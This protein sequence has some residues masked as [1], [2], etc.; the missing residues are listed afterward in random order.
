MIAHYLSEADA[1]AYHAGFSIASR[2]I[3]VL[4]V[5]FGAAGAP[6]MIHALEGGGEGALREEARR[7]IVLMALVLFPATAGIIAV[8]A[9]LSSLL[10]G[11]GL[12]SRALSITPLV[13]VGALLAGMNNSYF[14]LSFT[15]AKKTRLLVI[16]MAIPALANI[17]LNW[18]LIPRLGLVGAASAY[19]ASFVLGVLVAWALGFKARRMPTPLLELGKIA[20]AAAVMAAALR[21]IPPMGMAVDLMAKP[22]LGL[23]IY[24]ALAYGLDLGGARGLIDKALGRMAPAPRAAR[25]LL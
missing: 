24:G 10:I 8:A 21:L 18:L 15:L 6:A 5:W 12:R 22:A 17:A 9:P 14:L 19:L 3:E 1:G 2:V 7:Q 4:F 11:E 23:L 16:A 25:N 20:A 13:T